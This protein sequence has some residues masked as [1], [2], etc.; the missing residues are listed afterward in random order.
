M[1]LVDVRTWPIHKNLAV[2]TAF[3]LLMLVLHITLVQGDGISYGNGEDQDK[4]ESF[5][6][7]DDRHD[8]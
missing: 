2:V 4:G 8:E 3:L 6:Y 1:F 7:R 5:I